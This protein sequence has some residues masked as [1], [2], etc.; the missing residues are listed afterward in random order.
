MDTFDFK[1]GNYVIINKK[2]THLT[3]QCY[4]KLPSTPISHTSTYLFG[5]IKTSKFLFNYS[6]SNEIT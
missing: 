4:P 5:S 1:S 3:A 2:W 6:T